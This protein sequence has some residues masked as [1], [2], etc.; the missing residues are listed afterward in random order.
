MM[1]IFKV[2]LQL[3]N[4]K[5]TISILLFCSLCFGGLT[6]YMCSAPLNIFLTN[7]VMDFISKKIALSYLSLLAITGPMVFLAFNGFIEDKPIFMSL[8]ARKI[9]IFNFIISKILASL[10]YS[11]FTLPLVLII[12]QYFFDIKIIEICLLISSE[13]MLFYI[14]Y[15]AI[16]ILFDEKFFDIIMAYVIVLVCILTTFLEPLVIFSVTLPIFIGLAIFMYYRINDSVSKSLFKTKET[17]LDHINMYSI[18]LSNFILNK[19]INLISKYIRNFKFI[20]IFSKDLN[21]LLKFVPKPIFLHIAL[22]F[23]SPQYKFITILFYQFIIINFLKK[24]YNSDTILL[25]LKLIPYLEYYK[26]KIVI[27][28]LFN[29]IIQITFLYYQ[30]L[31][32]IIISTVMIFVFVFIAMICRKRFN[33]NNI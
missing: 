11:I 25:D 13:L 18:L 29:L 17:I 19:L 33:Q 7:E 5:K 14:I 30:V 16:Y 28:C 15:F 6:I 10:V 24:I 22:L 32:N 21:E 1:N 26:I 27:L 4:P 3:K 31:S 2:Q 9:N 8:L 20:A 12:N 23:V